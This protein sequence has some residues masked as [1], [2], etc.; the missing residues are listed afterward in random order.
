MAKGQSLRR[1]RVDRVV[2]VHD[3]L[4]AELAEQVREVERERV[5]VVDQQDQSRASASWIACSSAASLRRHSWCSAGGSES[6]TMPAPAWSSASPSWS[7]IVRIAMPVSSVP[8]GSEQPT[9]P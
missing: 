6:A 8:P 5:V 4:G 1:V 2:S 7:T 3:D 9:G